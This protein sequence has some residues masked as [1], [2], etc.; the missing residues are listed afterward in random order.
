MA[1][2]AL[3]NSLAGTQAVKISW[4][5]TATDILS[6]KKVSA[7]THVHNVRNGRFTGLQDTSVEQMPC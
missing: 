4:R 6:G 7:V 1:R 5:G 3:V 2:H